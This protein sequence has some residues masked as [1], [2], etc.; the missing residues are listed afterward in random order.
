M[1]NY[2]QPYLPGFEP[3]PMDSFPKVGYVYTYDPNDGEFISALLE[4]LPSIEEFV[5]ESN[6]NVVT[7]IYESNLEIMLGNSVGDAIGLLPSH[8]MSDIDLF[9]HV[10]KIKSTLPKDKLF[11]NFYYSKSEDEVGQIIYYNDHR[12]IWN[13]ENSWGYEYHFRPTPKTPYEEVTEKNIFINESDIANGIVLRPFE[14]KS[15]KGEPKQVVFIELEQFSEYVFQVFGINYEPPTSY[16]TCYV[17]VLFPGHVI[18][19][20][21]RNVISE[22]LNEG[23]YSD[24]L[25]SSLS[26]YL[27]RAGF[28]NH[29]YLYMLTTS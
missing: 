24:D 26:K 23:K 27:A 21:D 14:T 7:V 25:H 4:Y 5:L 18:A 13:D 17:N 10:G 12:L 16:E 22:W 11:P 2:T 3:I 8:V 6:D 9:T 19:E 20:W 15:D 29:E 28:L 1:S